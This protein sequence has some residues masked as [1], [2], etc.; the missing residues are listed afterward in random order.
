MNNMFVQAGIIAVLYLLIKFGEMRFVLKENKPI[1][2]LMRDTIIVYIS[3]IMG[4]YII[5][6]FM[7]QGESVKAVPKAFIDNPTF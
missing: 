3:A 5:D 7:L 6:Q 4:M 1:K 2:L